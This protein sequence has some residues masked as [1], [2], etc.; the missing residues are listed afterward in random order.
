MKHFFALISLLFVTVSFFQTKVS[1]LVYD[2]LGGTVPYAN[3]CFK[4]TR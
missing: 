3:V 1:G 2:D 4:G